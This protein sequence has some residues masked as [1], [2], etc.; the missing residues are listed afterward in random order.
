MN[1]VFALQICM[2]FTFDGLFTYLNYRHL[3]AN[4]DQPLNHDVTEENKSQAVTLGF[5][6]F[7]L[8]LMRLVP[9][10]VIISTELGKVFIAYIIR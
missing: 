3:T 2:L 4:L 9:L 10:D 1:Y 5:V 8:I 6:T 7:F